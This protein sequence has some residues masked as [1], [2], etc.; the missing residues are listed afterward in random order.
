M[1]VY[2]Y[3]YRERQYD[4]AIAVKISKKRFDCILIV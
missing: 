1:C 2:I 4:A 3:I